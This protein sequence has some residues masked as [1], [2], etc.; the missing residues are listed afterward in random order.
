M[1]GITV[2]S[3]TQHDLTTRGTLRKRNLKQSS[4]PQGIE[5]ALGQAHRAAQSSAWRKGEPF[6][7]D[8]AGLFKLLDR[9]G[10]RC[11]ITGIEFSDEPCGSSRKRPFIPSIDRIKAKEPYSLENC[12]LVCWAANLA[13]HDWGDEVF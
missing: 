8:A 4:A 11:E 5:F 12:R 1:S 9:S 7:L 3:L 10:G 6:D 13:L 2:E